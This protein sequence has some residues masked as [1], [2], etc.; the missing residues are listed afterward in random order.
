MSGD[1]K[2]IQA[3]KL[4]L[5]ENKM[6]VHECVGSLFPI[7]VADVC[8]RLLIPYMSAET[9][10]TFALVSR[11]ANA[12]T[13]R[14]RNVFVTTTLSLRARQAL[15]TELSMIGICDYSAFQTAL[16]A[17]EGLWSGSS[18]V[19]GLLGDN[20]KPFPTLR[21]AQSKCLDT[22]SVSCAVTTSDYA[23]DAIVMPVVQSDL[24]TTS[25]G[26]IM[27]TKMQSANGAHPQEADGVSEL[28]ALAAT[29]TMKV[30]ERQW[31]TRDLDFFIA[32]KSGDD[33]T[34][35]CPL[36]TF[37]DGYCERDAIAQPHPAVAALGAIV[38]G[39]RCY[40]TTAAV[41]DS[42]RASLLARD[43][44]SAYYAWNDV[45]RTHTNMD[46]SR[47]PQMATK[48]NWLWR[49]FAHDGYRVPGIVARRT[50]RF[51]NDR[52]VDL[53]YVDLAQIATAAA[54][55]TV[56][57]VTVTTSTT[58]TITTTGGITDNTSVHA[59]T[60]AAQES[61][62]QNMVPPATLQD[63]IDESFDLSILKNSFNGTRLVSCA[64]SC[65][66]SCSFDTCEM[67]PIFRFY[68]RDEWKHW[69]DSLADSNQRTRSCYATAF[70]RAT[71]FM[72]RGLT[73]RGLYC[74]C[75]IAGTRYWTNVQLGNLPGYHG[76]CKV[77]MAFARARNTRLTQTHLSHTQTQT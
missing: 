17:T 52:H 36:A 16:Q 69:V 58:S 68:P 10:F 6:F 56:S 27:E 9:W 19:K 41:R 71:K 43:N 24:S 77:N 38:L 29:A 34:K 51:S 55:T 54:D 63:W 75:S 26:S 35:L 13:T 32:L 4:R 74:D 53:V 1:G 72:R 46:G 30:R 48:R 22:G 37:F 3:K 7:R 25:V 59:E 5:N 62:A 39:S 2:G 76:Y 42:T 23:I 12:W 8:L 66:Q 65:L 44:Q 18:L 40:M 14:T 70:V 64:Y 67:P 33:L 60:P 73:M 11:A 20:P 28:S 31:A 50:F 15:E 57:I 45:A 47:G 61:D 21:T 49:T